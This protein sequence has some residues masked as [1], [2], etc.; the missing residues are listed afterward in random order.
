[1]PHPRNEREIG[2]VLYFR[3]RSFH[4]KLGV[5]MLL[6]CISVGIVLVTII[7][8]I[9]LAFVWPRLV[10]IGIIGLWRTCHA[11]ELFDKD[12][13]Q[14]VIPA[15]WSLVIP[16]SSD[17]I[18]KMIILQKVNQFPASWTLFLDYPEDEFIISHRNI[19]TYVRYQ[20]VGFMSHR[21]ESS[22]QRLVTLCLEDSSETQHT[23]AYCSYFPYTVKPA[24]D[25]IESNRI[26][27]VSRML[28]FIQVVGVWILVTVKVIR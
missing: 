2:F 18:D 5:R 22:I 1:M 25:G 13:S 28:H 3:R 17:R 23:V 15:I 16:C 21:T 9:Q 4:S 11:L 26:F 7:L 10:G 14:L 27:S 24:Y 6:W 20:S 19:G 8:S 12:N